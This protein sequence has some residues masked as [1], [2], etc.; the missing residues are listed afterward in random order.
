[1][2]EI[3]SGTSLLPSRAGAVA[4]SLDAT[5]TECEKDRQIQALQD[6]IVVLKRE[7]VRLRDT[8][9]LDKVCYR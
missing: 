7:L 5:A 2:L 1:M 6:E 3:E 8:T 9:V 4:R